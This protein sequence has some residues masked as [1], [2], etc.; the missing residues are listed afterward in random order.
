M[1]AFIDLS[2]GESGEVLKLEKGLYVTRTI[3]SEVLT[4]L[5]E[6]VQADQNSMVLIV[7]EA[8]YGDTRCGTPLRTSVFS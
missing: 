8:G 7:G 3:E 1:P 4:Y 5:F 6:K 2:F